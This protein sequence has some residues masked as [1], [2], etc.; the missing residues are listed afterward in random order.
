[1]TLLLT[2][3]GNRPRKQHPPGDIR[4]RGRLL[5][6]CVFADP[7]EPTKGVVVYQ[8]E[9]ILVEGSTHVGL[10]N[11]KTNGVGD[12]YGVSRALATVLYHLP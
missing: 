2:R 8:W 3:R 10:T 1:M 6:V 9:T 4:H 5:L 12:T 11:G 7:V